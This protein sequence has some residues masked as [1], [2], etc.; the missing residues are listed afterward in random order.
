MELNKVNY[1][2]IEEC[3]LAADSKE[4]LDQIFKASATMSLD[5]ELATL[6]GENLPAVLKTLP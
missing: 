1:A 4:F 2:V 3:L 6:K 5:S